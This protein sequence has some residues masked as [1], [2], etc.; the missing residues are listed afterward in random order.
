M[1]DR[2]ERV[3]VLSAE[4][5]RLYDRVPISHEVA[6]ERQRTKLRRAKNGPERR[7]ARFVLAQMEGRTGYGIPP[8]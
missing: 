2:L 6:L 5:H 1:V 3:V 4:H 8:V 7:V